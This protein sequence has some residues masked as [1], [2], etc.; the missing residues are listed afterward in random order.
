MMNSK[1]NRWSYIQILDDAVCVSHNL[2]AFEKD[3]NLVLLLALGKYLG[4]Y[5]DIFGPWNRYIYN[6]ESFYRMTQ[7]ILE[8]LVKNL[9]KSYVALEVLHYNFGGSNH[10]ENYSCD[11]MRES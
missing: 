11:L 5:W 8:N 1:W 10:V 7:R 6:L 2:I 9:V 4:K 3:M